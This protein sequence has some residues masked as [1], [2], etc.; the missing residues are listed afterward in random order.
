MTKSFKTAMMHATELTRAGKLQQATALIQSLLGQGAELLDSD[1]IEGTFSQVATQAPVQKPKP[2][3]ISATPRAGLADTLRRIAAGGMPGSRPVSGTTDP[4]PPGAQFLSLRHTTATA[5]RN[6]RLYLPANQ[7]EALMPLIIM[8]HGCTQSP[9]DF[10]AGTNMNALAEE[11]GCLVA[12]PAQPSGV[13]AQKCWNWFR[14][15]DQGRD[16]GEPALIAGLTKDIL[17]N[18]KAD[19]ARVYIAGLSAGGAAAAIIAAA[20]P[21]LYQAAGVHSGLPVGAAQDLPSAFSAMRSGAAGTPLPRAVPTIVFHGLAD[22]TVHPG[23]GAAVIA[24]ALTAQSDLRRTTET[25]TSAGGRTYRLTR[26]NA[27]DGRI[28]AEHWEITGAGHAW[29]GGRPSGS[30]TDPAGP[31]ASREMLRFF[32]NHPKA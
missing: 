13:N 21:D 8:L 6:Y 5:S 22:P 3:K 15:E 31:D 20:Y 7:P 32:L 1:A 10:A 27:A 19:P 12:Y 25:G 2:R 23:N 9:E 26:H 28:L 29:A 11:F 24:Q 18:H 30:Y 16:H 17:K 14:A 4:I